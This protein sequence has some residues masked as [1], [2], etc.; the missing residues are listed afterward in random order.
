MVIQMK[1]LISNRVLVLSPLLMVMVL[2]SVFFDMQHIC[3]GA[4]QPN[5]L[6]V[7]VDDLRPELGCYGNPEVKT[8][9]FDAFSEQAVTFKRAYC[10]AAVCA[11]SRA[12]VM[13]GLRPDTNRV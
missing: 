2:L 4:H 12:S 6:F 11:P 10:Q 13:T 7:I 9:V 8:P 5:V 1:T 3:H